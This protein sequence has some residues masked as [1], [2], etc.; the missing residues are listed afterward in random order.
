MVIDKYRKKLKELEKEL[1]KLREEYNDP[2]SE[3]EDLEI[4]KTII[5]NQIKMHEEDIKDIKEY[6]DTYNKLLDFIEKYG[7][8]NG[9]EK[10]DLKNEILKL[11]EKIPQDLSE[12]VYQYIEEVAERK[13]KEQEVLFE[14]RNNIKTVEYEFVN[15]YEEKES[16]KEEEQENLTSE[17]DIVLNGLD[18]KLSLLEEEINH[19]IERL[20]QTDD[21]NQKDK[22]SA[23]LEEKK[24]IF[25]NIKSDLLN[26]LSEYKT[27]FDKEYEDIN[28]IHAGEETLY[29]KYKNDKE[30]INEISKKINDINIKKKKC[31]NNQNK[32]EDLI[33]KY[34]NYSLNNKEVDK[35]E[36]KLKIE[37]K[38]YKPKLTWKT[39]VAIAAGAGVGA[40]V[41]F[42][43]GPLGVTVLNVAAGISKGVVAKKQANSNIDYNNEKIKIKEVSGMSNKLKSSFTNLKTYL[44]SKEGLR[45]IS[46]FLTSAIVTGSALSI[47]NG[48][49]NYIASKSAPATINNPI[50]EVPNSVTKPAINPTGAKNSSIYSNIKIQNGVGNYDV[51]S[52]YDKASWAINHTNKESLISE[53]VNKAKS[54]FNK[55]VVLNP[56]GTIGAQCTTP[57]MSIEQFAAS[58]GVDVSKVAVL[59]S[60]KSGTAQA[61]TAA[62][63]LVKSIGAMK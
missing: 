25:N 36:K 58:Q 48:I 27:K 23:E 45:E 63:E 47:G 35:K 20:N 37:K 57:G 26:I 30:K 10:E 14:V 16:S 24:K 17:D 28:L 41:Y 9:K 56:D 59:V 8:L 7:D 61:W 12:E 19:L 49:K 5:N 51:S 6:I 39:A 2:I 54:V 13:S 29:R 40:T 32:A 3:F 34:K 4:T 15:D 18:D 38:E 42:T 21:K 44:K 11:K 52:G 50:K 46:W 43:L 60:D 31:F 53:Y 1:E 22:L 33:E 55:F 62:S